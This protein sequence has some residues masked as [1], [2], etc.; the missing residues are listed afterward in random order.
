[1]DSFGVCVKLQIIFYMQ[2]K[3]MYIT[4]QLFV[5]ES[6]HISYKWYSALVPKFSFWFQLPATPKNL[7]TTQPQLLDL[8]LRSWEFWNNYWNR[9][10]RLELKEIIMS[11]IKKKKKKKNIKEIRENE[12]KILPTWVF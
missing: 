3:W 1:M 4:I 9:L 11:L 10:E 2:A 5:Y 7:D 12:N 8:G 6:I